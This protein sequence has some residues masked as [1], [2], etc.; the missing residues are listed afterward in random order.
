MTFIWPS[1]LYLLLIIPLFA[2]FYLRSQRRR[3]QIAED[4]GDLGFNQEVGKGRLGARRHIPPLLF[5]CGLIVMLVALARPQMTLALPSIESTIILAFD[6][7]GSM[8]ADDMQ[9]TRMEAAKAAA[10]EFALRQPSRVQIGVVAFSDGGISVQVPTHDREAILAAINRLRP[11]QGTSLANGILAALN[12]ISPIEGEA[13]DP[14]ANLTPLPTATAVAAGDFTSAVVVMLTDGE[15]N[16]SPDPIEAAHLAADRGVR[17]Y[18]IGVGSPQGTTLEVNG[19]TVFTQLDEGLLRQISLISGGSYF[20][21]QSEDD[22]NEI[23]ENLDI[24]LVV[25][26]Q[27]TEVTSLFTGVGIIFLLFGGAF[28]LLW[29]SRIP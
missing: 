21:A 5:L 25:K 6:V 28:S 4:L 15:N 1:T 2:V 29:F 17:L 9:P 23:Y 26:P 11:Q 12:V 24:Q 13:T 27:K 7:S 3:R 19:F 16:Q 22:L 10:R 20:Q 8:A 18:T 14:S